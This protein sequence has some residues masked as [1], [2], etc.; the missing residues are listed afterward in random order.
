MSVINKEWLNEM[1]RKQRKCVCDLKV[2]VPY[3]VLGLYLTKSK[4][5]DETPVAEVKLNNEDS[6]QVYLPARY[7]FTREDLA[8][9]IDE[10]LKLIYNGRVEQSTS[11]D[12]MFV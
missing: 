5:S 2:G 3:K 4:Y 9:G 8:R 1:K 10:N 6:F 11:Y 12:I 7:T